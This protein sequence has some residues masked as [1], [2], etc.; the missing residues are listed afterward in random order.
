MSNL[1]GEETIVAEPELCFKSSRGVWVSSNVLLGLALLC[2]AMN[3]HVLRAF[4]RNP[5]TEIKN[6]QL[7]PGRPPK[8][9]H[10]ICF[11]VALSRG[12]EG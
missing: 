8:T 6:S 4:F 5:Y 1:I 7:P 3:R 10:G 2:T 12:N 11:F 9:K